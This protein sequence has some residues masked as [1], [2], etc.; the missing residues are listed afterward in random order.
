MK[1]GSEGVVRGT[2]IAKF[3]KA[4]YASGF[5]YDHHDI[6]VWPALALNYT[7]KTQYLFRINKGSLHVHDHSIINKFVPREERPTPFQNIVYIGDG[8]TDVPCFRLV[9]EQGGH[10]IAVYEPNTK[11]AK[12][13]CGEYLEQGRVR[14]VAPAD[15]REGEKLDLIVKA[16]IDKLSADYHLNSLTS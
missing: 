12:S 8:E 2:D 9:S 5:I 6:A 3:F 13:R 4:I 16:I 11:K 15:Y 14:F 1:R 10:S 7:T